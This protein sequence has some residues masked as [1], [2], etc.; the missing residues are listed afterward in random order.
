MSRKQTE[1]F[2]KVG[3]PRPDDFVERVNW[4]MVHH[5]AGLKQVE[6]ANCRLWHWP[7]EM[8][9]KFCEGCVS[10]AKRMRWKLA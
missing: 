10:A 7:H 1:P 2:F 9:G 8:N 3:D 6:C 5:K 4:E